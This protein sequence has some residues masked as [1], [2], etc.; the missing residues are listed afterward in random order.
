[1]VGITY[2]DNDCFGELSEVYATALTEAQEK[3]LEILGEKAKGLGANAVVGV[4]IKVVKKYGTVEDK[5][6]LIVMAS[7][8]AVS[9][10]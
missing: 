6:M 1:V 2:D 8:T 10:Y 5:E 9:V 7:G 3:A 4:D